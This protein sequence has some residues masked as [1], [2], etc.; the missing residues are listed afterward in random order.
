[1]SIDGLQSFCYGVSA[2]AIAVV[3]LAIL[4]WVKGKARRMLEKEYKKLS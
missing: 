1:M 4:N 2:I 3:F